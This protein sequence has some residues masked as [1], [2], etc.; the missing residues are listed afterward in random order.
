[1]EALPLNLPITVSELVCFTSS[2]AVGLSVPIPILPSD[3]IRIASTTSPVPSFV[4][5][6]ISDPLVPSYDAI[7]AS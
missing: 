1:M 5:M 3:F 6:E 7:V 2:F 4:P